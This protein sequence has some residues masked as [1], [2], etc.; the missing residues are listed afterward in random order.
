MISTGNLTDRRQSGAKLQSFENQ[1][2][3][4]YRAILERVYKND[5]V[6]KD[7]FKKALGLIAN[8]VTGDGN[9]PSLISKLNDDIR[10]IVRES[11]HITAAR[12]AAV[13]MAA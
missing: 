12:T 2:V 3:D 11:V 10:S 6:D 1:Y 5:S 8:L 7:I 13:E 4:T 9:R